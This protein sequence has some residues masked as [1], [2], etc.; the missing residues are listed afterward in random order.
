[1]AT[2]SPIIVYG[3][4]PGGTYVPT[5]TVAPAASPRGLASLSVQ[6]IALRALAII[7]LL[8]INKLG[9]G[10]AVVFFLFL[11]GMMLRSP[12]S[13]FVA[14]L[15]GMVGLVTNQSIVPK[16]IVW[17]PLRLLLP[18]VVAMRFAFDLAHQR[19]SVFSDGWFLALCAFVVV[20][21]MC[22]LAGGYYVPISMLKLVNFAV[23]MGAVFSAVKAL[24]GRRYD[25]TEWMLAAMAVIVFNGFL[26]IATGVAYRIPKAGEIIDRSTL[27]FQGP[28]L[29]ANVAG[30]FCA[31]AAVLLFSFW[32]TTPYRRSWLALLLALPLIYFLWLSRSRTG[33]LSLVI[34]LAIAFLTSGI[35]P[36][37]R[38][39]RRGLG[40]RRGQVIAGGVLVVAAVV[41]YELST[42]GTL[43]LG[44]V[45]FLNKYDRTATE[46]EMEDVLGSR[47]SVIMQQWETFLERPL[48]GI[49]FQVAKSEDFVRNATLFSAPVEKGFLPTALLEEVGL[50]GAAT[51]ATF[52]VMLSA[53]LILSGNGPGLTMFLTYLTTNLGEMTIFAFGGAGGMGWLFV[54]MGILIGMRRNATARALAGAGGR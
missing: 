17:T 9:N 50:L 51:F 12:E 34:G 46:I 39:L 10:G 1:M 7:A 45:R 6:R 15:I 13:A 18:Y 53:A 26:A 36:R 19:K 11:G 16:T 28:F 23:G 21:A 30:P 3:S 40:R 49:G 44:V 38:L 43:T 14:F 37:L 35:A 24:Q 47:Q 2:S 41:A 48:T 52:V 42:G 27:F 25:L 33:L 8:L 32:L 54:A 29:H 5:V 4:D 20:S 31:L 22:S